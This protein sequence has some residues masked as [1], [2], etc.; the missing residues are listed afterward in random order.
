MKELI[1]ATLGAREFDL[2]SF[3]KVADLL[4]Y[5]GP[6]LSLF[7]TKEGDNYL[8][9]WVDC[10]EASNRWLVFQITNEQLEAYRCARSS[11]R[12]L[13]FS[14]RNGFIYAVDLDDEVG[15]S[16]AKI[17][18]PHELPNDYLPGENAFYEG[19]AQVVRSST[20]FSV[21]IAGDWNIADLYRF[22]RLLSHAYAFLCHFGRESDLL[23]N[24]P[25]FPMRD[26]FSSMHFFREL[27]EA[28]PK[29][30]ALTFE[31][32]RYASPGSIVFD[33]RP[34]TTA[35]LFC[36][37]C[38][39][40]ED[41]NAEIKNSYKFLQ[42]LLADKKLLG[43]DVLNVT[44]ED[45]FDRHLKTLVRDFL[46]VLGLPNFERIFRKCSNTLMAAKVALAFY[47]LLEERLL[48]Y[49]RDERI[50]IPTVF[51]L[52][53]PSKLERSDSPSAAQ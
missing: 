47:R 27:W 33:G 13:M 17:V 48:E 3:T 34:G 2:D 26:G 53:N 39:V 25:S 10:D 18:S 14:P 42:S 32:M 12:D 30:A 21:P 11:L 49:E 4:F 46:M 9:S 45:D 37:L 29:P 51:R 1:G 19:D 28:I 31:G 15:V 38:R 23:E 41:P 52:A 40:K 8:F 6:L 36:L 35:D 5:D 22:P 44:L 7:Q 50:A 16:Q 20:R 24:L 43:Q